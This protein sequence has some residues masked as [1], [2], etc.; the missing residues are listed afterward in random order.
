MSGGCAGWTTWE[1]RRKCPDPPFS[2]HDVTHRLMHC[3]TTT[4][5]SWPW[6]SRGKRFTSMQD[7]KKVENTTTNAEVL[8]VEGDQILHRA[9][10]TD[11]TLTAG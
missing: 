10:E 3:A 2:G 6:P 1:L 4:S 5:L 8:G 11:E 9:R 7:S